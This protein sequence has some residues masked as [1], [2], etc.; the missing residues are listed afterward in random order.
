MA[1][2]RVSNQFELN[3]AVDDVRG[4]D[5]ILLES[6][7]Y[8]RLEMYA[9][10]WNE[11]LR[12]DEKVTI[13]SANPNDQAELHQLT[14]EHQTNLEFRDITFKSV[15][16]KPE[17]AF[18]INDGENISVVDCT[19][20]GRLV[21]GLGDGVGL[22][23][24][25]S[26]D[27]RLSGSEFHDFRN[28]IYASTSSDVDILNNDIRGASN[29]GMLLGGLT[30]ALIQGNDLRDAHSDPQLQHKDGIQFY[31][32]SE[33]GASH[34]I[35]VRDNVIVNGEE[36]HGIYFTNSGASNG[37]LGL[38]Y[39]NILIEGNQLSTAHS[40]GITMNHG[41]DVVIRNNEIGQNH[42]GG[43]HDVLNVPRIH[44]STLSENVTITGNQVASVP[45]RAD[46]SWTVA[47][48][49]TIR[50]MWH[51]NGIG[52]T[53][54]GPRFFGGGGGGGGGFGNSAQDEFR[55]NGDRDGDH[56]VTFE[57]VDFS[58]GDRVIFNGLDRDTFANRFNG[59]PFGV[60]DDGRAAMVNGYGD[61][62]EMIIAS[63]A[64]HGEVLADDTLRL[65]FDQ[66]GGP[67]VVNL[68]G[69]GDAV[70]ALL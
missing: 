3:E 55:Y 8:D 2:I 13:A 27:F 28:A 32:N 45:L 19:F 64:V 21:G 20:Q 48:N 62:A 65:I 33:E 63:D 12:F 18:W 25:N 35:V 53:D 9:N 46:A 1:V 40:H 51:W 26:D 6:G 69:V 15:V 57:D 29:D 16:G 39:R 5:T 4:G 37:N 68:G 43:H 30:R 34:D 49:D 7:V 60:W 42:S 61:L 66:Q 23:V 50:Q 52:A 24:R 70:E 54:G 67:G 56:P 10:G 11:H 22:R 36:T 14:S 44:V 47:N 59:N 58:E 41:E 31:A 17:D 38:K